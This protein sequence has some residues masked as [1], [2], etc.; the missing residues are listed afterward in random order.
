MRGICFTYSAGGIKN[1]PLR[2]E[3]VAGGCDSCLKENQQEK[4]KT[5]QNLNSKGN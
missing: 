4:T 5:K 2:N 3:M 1:S